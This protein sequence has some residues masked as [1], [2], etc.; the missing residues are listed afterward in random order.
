MQLPIEL[1]TPPS[2]QGV[3]MAT[4][5]VEAARRITA[6]RLVSASESDDG[7]NPWEALTPQRKIEF[8]RGLVREGVGEAV[9]ELA[10]A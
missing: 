7:A 4:N 8:L 3:D 10:K 1:Q 5:E 6:S 2:P 9:E